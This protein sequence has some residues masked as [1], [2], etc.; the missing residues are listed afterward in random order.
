MLLE[1]LTSLCG[2]HPLGEKIVV[3]P[4]LAVG[5]QIG[6]ALAYSGTAWVNLRFETIR[7]LVD[8]VVGF[9]LAMEGVRV[10]SR[11]QA[12]SL[13]ESA[14]DRVIRDG[15]YFERLADRPGLHRAIQRSLD[16]LRLAGVALTSPDGFENE[17]KARDLAAIVAEYESQ[18]AREHFIDRAG[19][20]VR[21]IR[22]LESGSNPWGES[23]SWTILDDVDLSAGEQLFLELASA[24]RLHH[25]ESHQTVPASQQIELVRAIGEENEIR[26]A[27]R[28]LLGQPA[29]FDSAEIVYSRRDPYL[30]LAY[31]LTQELGIPATFAEGIAAPYTTPGRACL[32]YLEWVGSDWEAR[33]LQAAA[34][35]GAITLPALDLDGESVP[36][37]GTAF[38]R[39]V[40]DA[41]IGWG[42]DRYLA[43]V[44]AWIAEKNVGLAQDDDE[45]ISARIARELASARAIRALFVQL[46]EIS[47]PVAAGEEIEITALARSAARFVK[48]LARVRSEIDGMASSALQRMLEELADLPRATAP[49]H[50]A[51]RRLSEALRELHV[52]SS[53][54][55]PGHLHVA[56]LHSG[57]WSGRRHVFIVGLD[58]AK[59]PGAALQDPILLDSERTAINR[60]LGADRLQMRGESPERTVKRF[61]NLLHRLAGRDSDTHDTIRISWP[62]FD[63]IERRSLYPSSAVLEAFRSSRSLDGGTYDDA[64]AAAKTA[65]FVGVPE[66]TMSEWWQAQRVEGSLAAESVHAEYPWLGNGTEAMRARES[67]ELTKWDGL[68][69]APREEIDPRYTGRV[70]SAS[71][72]ERMAQCPIGYFFERHLRVRPVEE[73]ERDPDVWLDARNSGSLFHEIAERFMKTVCRDGAVPSISDQQVLHEIAEDAMA[74]WRELVPPPNEL[75]YARHREELF[76]TL[77]VFFRGELDCGTVRAKY[78]EAAFGSAAE[79]ADGI[80]TSEPF[81]LKLGGG[82]SIALRGKIDRVD[83]DEATGEWHV[84]DYKTGSTYS[85]HPGDRLA[86]GTKL[87]HAIY[88]K[89]ICA[90]LE[91]HGTEAV[92]GRSGYYFPTR[93]GLALK[94]DRPCAEGELENA[95]NLLFDVV[96]SGFFPQPHG[97]SC[98]WCEYSEARGGKQAAEQM[99]RKLEAHP[100]HPAVRAWMALQEVR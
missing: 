63:L 32:A 6:D 4:S 86:R 92:V 20:L 7:T 24:G 54:P 77:D 94:Q 12:L 87:Q 30:P 23:T 5:H 99:A 67:E 3:V 18:L 93:K 68:I 60:R 14:C 47:E 15:S 9:D 42:R 34:R 25:V 74:A 81:I 13:V 40:R 71:Q 97:E 21:A 56:P 31:E 50:E 90:M 75:A 100:D 8:A 27:L 35:A 11:A 55:R 79:S 22:K 33:I 84:W 88:A 66:L 10:L 1:R 48:E 45:E 41:A 82:R 16:D 29:T 28:T 76:E 37:S 58:D 59:Y 57:G 19:V 98:R 38:T 80:S 61:R 46:L 73:L 64:S 83:Y 43:R 62:S 26:A 95:L 72:L 85:F 65:G 2:E 36:L 69:Q 39:I 78:F 70:Y 89:A 17:R 49:R 91:R 52:S 44:D 51:T 53:N 96:G